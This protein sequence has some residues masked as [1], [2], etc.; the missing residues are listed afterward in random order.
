MIHIYNF[1]LVHLLL[2]LVHILVVVRRSL[3]NLMHVVLNLRSC[4]R[5]LSRAQLWVLLVRGRKVRDLHVLV[6][7]T[8]LV[9]RVASWLLSWVWLES[10]L[11]FVIDLDSLANR[12]LFLRRW[13]QRLSR[14]LVGWDWLINIPLCPTDKVVF[15]ILLEMIA[16]KIHMLVE[17]N[18]HSLDIFHQRYP[19]W[20]CFCQFDDLVFQVLF[21]DEFA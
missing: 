20:A 16:L 7:S 12:C 3:S 10:R 17:L 4:T 21:G 11:R 6:K 8:S 19:L 18:E 15:D 9:L 13:G 2:L 1:V 14:S 5:I